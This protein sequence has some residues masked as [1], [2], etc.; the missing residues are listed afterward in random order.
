MTIFD[1]GIPL[2]DRSSAAVHSKAYGHAVVRATE[3]G[4]QIEVA[5]PNHLAAGVRGPADRLAIVM[6]DSRLIDVG[7][8]PLVVYLTRQPGES[9]RMSGRF[10]HAGAGSLQIGRFSDGHSSS[11]IRGEATE[12]GN[13]LR[14]WA[15]MPYDTEGI[16]GSSSLM[17]DLRALVAG[18]FYSLAPAS[19]WFDSLDANRA[20]SMLLPGGSRTSNTEA[21]AGAETG[22]QTWANQRVALPLDQPTCV[23]CD[24]VEDAK[25]L[26]SRGEL[27]EALWSLDQTIRQT[28]STDLAWQA[29]MVEKQ[30]LSARMGWPE[31]SVD[32][33]EQLLRSNGLWEGFLVQSLRG[34]AETYL[35]TKSH[36]PT[37]SSIEWARLIEAIG[38]GNN[39]AA[40]GGDLLL[41]MGMRQ[42]AIR[43]WESV[44]ANE[45]AA[46]TS[47]AHS[48]LRLQQIAIGSQEWAAAARL[49][50]RLQT[51]TAYDLKLRGYSLALF[52]P[53]LNQDRIGKTASDLVAKLRTNL[54]LDA[55][56]ICKHYFTRGDA[57]ITACPL[58]V[59][60][61]S[62]QDAN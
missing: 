50:E 46:R 23:H 6:W 60:K 14:F 22:P 26:I 9:T 2:R 37:V 35:K 49:A 62:H 31:Q 58:Q 10:S 56:S 61:E 51:E 5:I 44:I 59:E 34:L 30:N 29:A 47:R 39:R 27:T 55:E 12:G 16:R 53:F 18:E 32:T 38:D 45:F 7:S 20:V 57:S 3:M 52:T 15:A 33:A 8:E 25:R 40:F 17:L 24:A 11:R 41:L 54:R 36:A 1:G 28:C 13:V 42:E 19:G 43:A 21:R 48:L 4:I